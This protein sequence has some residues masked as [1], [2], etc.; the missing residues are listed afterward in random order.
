MGCPSKMT[1]EK[2]A[3]WLGFGVEWQDWETVAVVAAPARL[4][5]AIMDGPHTN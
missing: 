3:D 1:L 4:A 2:P 5:G